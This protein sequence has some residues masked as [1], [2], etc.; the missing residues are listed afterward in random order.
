M[1]QKRFIVSTSA[2]ACGLCLFIG[3]VPSCAQ[4]PGESKD[5][6]AAPPVAK[7]ATVVLATAAPAAAA[8]VAAARKQSEAGG[9]AIEFSREAGI[10][11]G[12]ETENAKEQAEKFVTEK[13]WTLDA[14]SDGFFAVVAN[15]SLSCG[16]DSKTFQQ[17]REMAFEEALMNAKAKLAEFMRMQVSTQLEK[18]VIQI[19]GV[20]S[21][22][23]IA[24]SN[25][26]SLLAKAK[27]LMHNE[28]DKLMAERGIKLGTP[29][30]EKAQREFTGEV[31]EQKNFKSAVLVQA[32]AELSGLQAFRTF[33][34]SLKGKKGSI[35][36]V[37]I[38]SPKSAQLHQALLGKGEAPRAEAQ[39]S[40][41]E[42]A[43]TEGPKVLL[44]TQGTQP[45]TNEKGEV[46]LVGF[47]QSA[48]TSDSEL[49]QEVA[50][51]KAQMAAQAALRRFMG[52][53]IVVSKASEQSS[54]LKEYG[55]VATEFQSNSS[56]SKKM[57]ATG[58]LLGMSGA[59]EIYSWSAVHPGNG[60]KVYGSVY[61][62][63]VSQA[64][65]ANA[66]Y[67]DMQKAGGAAGG[68]GSFGVAPP[69]KAPPSQAAKKVAPTGKDSKG[70]G[71]E[72]DTP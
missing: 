43:Q 54:S 46:V 39:I 19:G 60:K 56:F 16:P 3:P 48:A 38:H 9:V 41:R 12:V 49:S 23:P 22:D 4:A 51:E 29:E 2:L 71:A 13:G 45:R 32:R 31:L 53:L 50:E 72:G 18:D 42:W 24:Q 64:R 17:C 36:V 40:I 11:E 58:S 30:A 7:P 6:Q 14:E 52:E 26:N 10:G 8:P 1:N 44:F 28:V 20:N 15:A 59:K 70:Q 37:A 57:S 35:A 69:P 62:Y 21:P 68:A 63:S 25:D 33:E 66:M 47:G 61:V 67:F 65:A 27:L 55:E 5:S 34:T